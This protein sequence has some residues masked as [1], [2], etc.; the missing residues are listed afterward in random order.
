[1]SDIKPKDPGMAKLANRFW[2]WALVQVC[3]VIAIFAW[4]FHVAVSAYLTH[5]RDGDL[6]AHS[7]SFQAIV[8]LIFVVPRLFAGMAILLGLE[9]FAARIISKRQAMERSP[10]V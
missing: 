7:W 5:P 8:V 2:F 1:M 9:W 4:R 3:V 6:Y 10:S